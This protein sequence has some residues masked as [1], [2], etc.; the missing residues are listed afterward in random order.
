[1]TP[2]PVLLRRAVAALAVASAACA[3]PDAAS[4]P[5]GAD[6][7]PPP[8]RGPAPTLYAPLGLGLFRQVAAAK[9]GENAFVS[10]LS[11]GMALAMV[12]NGATGETQRQM[13]EV[14]GLDAR[15]VDEVNAANRELRAAL[16]SAGVELSVA[17][18]LWARRG[19][20]FEAAFTERVRAAYGAEVA[21]VSFTDPATAARIN[22]WVARETRGRIRELVQA[23][24]D[25][26]LVLYLT[27]AVYFKGR[28]AD[29]FPKSATRDRPF[30]LPGGTA[31]PRPTM[32][33][34]GRYGYREGDGFRAVRLP[35][36]GGRMALYVFLPDSSSSLAAF[37]ERLTAARWDRWMTEF[38]PR[39]VD[40]AL[41]RFRAEGTFPLV[42][43]LGALGM[44]DAFDP[45]RA[46]LRAMLP[47]SFFRGGRNVFIS[48][49]VQKTWIEVNEEGTEAA[50]ATGLGVSV[51]SAPPP[52]VPFVVD[53]PF[54][55]AVRDDRTGALLFVG[56][57]T[58]P[59]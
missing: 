22:A 46:S 30:R 28:W 2:I 53:R 9:P 18:A 41:P 16:R 48:E 34:M 35:Y 29:E 42:E 39:E 17:N 54:I 21:E 7:I 11:A 27:N 47:A 4:A 56:Q 1:M 3:P 13:A 8:P 45:A 37:R 40:V 26:A 43:P 58:D 23:P 36:R 10:P 55:A 33:R 15:G 51:T 14:L 32:H 25:P 38:A 49:A 44:R 5:R 12:Y 20:P 50:A 59:R 6:T 57:V 52:P 31:S 24:M 19:V